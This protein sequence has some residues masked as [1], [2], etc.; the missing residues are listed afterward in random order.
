M[1]KY[2]NQAFTLSKILIIMPATLLSGFVPKVL[3]NDVEQRLY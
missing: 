3:V 2:I 1:N